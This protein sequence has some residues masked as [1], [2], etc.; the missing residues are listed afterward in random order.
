M[1]E[2]YTVVSIS[3]LDIHRAMWNDSKNIMYLKLEKELSGM[4]FWTVSVGK[5]HQDVSTYAQ[6]LSVC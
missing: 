5:V 6:E 1:F 2:F 3:E 4:W